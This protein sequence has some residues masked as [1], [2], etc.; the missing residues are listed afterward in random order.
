MENALNKIL[1]ASLLA[2]L[3]AVPALAKPTDHPINN[4]V[5]ALTDPG[6]W[7]EGNVVLPPYPL[8][9]DWVGS[10]V[11]LKSNYSYFVD[12]KTLTRTDDGVIRLIL[13]MVSSTGAE[14]LSYEGIQCANRSLRS[15]AFGDS[16]NHS[17]IESTRV[18]WKRMDRDDKVRMR[19]AENFCPDWDVPAT[20]AEAL[21]RLKKAP[22]N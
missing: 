7:V 22:K 19:L 16:Y 12:S 5:Y 4:E 8:Q 2:T 1:L 9:A 11:P 17:W 15:Y 21:S 10:S 18:L 20:A 13:R 6:E 3:V 14:N